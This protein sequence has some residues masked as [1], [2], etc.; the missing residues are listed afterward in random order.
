MKNLPTPQEKFED[1]SST[2]DLKLMETTAI[3]K[4]TNYE[5]DVIPLRGKGGYIINIH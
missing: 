4:Y 3:M 5:S 1:P 2:L